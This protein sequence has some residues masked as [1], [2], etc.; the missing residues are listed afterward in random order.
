MPFYGL[1]LFINRG[2][3][4]DR[5]FIFLHEAHEFIDRGRAG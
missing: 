5:L 3:G 4:H 1:L 2:K